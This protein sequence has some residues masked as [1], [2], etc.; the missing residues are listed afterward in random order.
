M[1]T[2][3]AVEVRIPRKGI[4]LVVNSYRWSCHF[5]MVLR[6]FSSARDFQ[7]GELSTPIASAV[8]I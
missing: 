1:H 6:A 7:G 5:A 2:L 4:M 8:P 3:A